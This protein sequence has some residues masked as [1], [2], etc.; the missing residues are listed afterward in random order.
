MKRRYPNGYLTFDDYCSLCPAALARSIF[1]A[2]DINRDGRISFSEYMLALQGDRGSED[3][4]LECASVSFGGFS[5][6]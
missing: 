5:Q 3:R 2:S 6:R 1:T 4:W